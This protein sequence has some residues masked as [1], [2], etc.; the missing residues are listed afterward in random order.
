MNISTIKEVA[1]LF[2]TKHYSFNKKIN[3]KVA[4]IEMYPRLPW[5]LEANPFGSAEHTVGTT[6]PDQL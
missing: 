5:E 2:L 1:Q 3:L 4:I 6:G